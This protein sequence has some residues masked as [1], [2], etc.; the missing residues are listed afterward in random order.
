MGL[1]G[2]HL[3]HRLRLRCLPLLQLKLALQWLQPGGLG[4]SFVTQQAS[5]PPG[6]MVFLSYSFLKLKHARH[7][8]TWVG[9]HGN[10][11]VRSTVLSSIGVMTQPQWVHIAECEGPTAQV[12]G[13]FVGIDASGKLAQVGWES[14]PS[15]KLLSWA[16]QWLQYQAALHRNLSR[17]AL[18]VPVFKPQ[19][20]AGPT[21]GRAFFNQGLPR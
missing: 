15:L 11:M 16:G 19:V 18:V 3:S 14:D 2:L 10:R 17:P 5:R 20:T 9:P 4:A 1:C 13:R 21:I 8:K 6:I 12:P 7:S